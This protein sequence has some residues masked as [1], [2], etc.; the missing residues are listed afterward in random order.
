MSGRLKTETAPALLW[1]WLVLDF[2]VLVPKKRGLGF[3]KSPLGH[4]HVPGLS[5]IEQIA[6][7]DIFGLDGALLFQLNGN[8]CH[9]T[10]T[11]KKSFVDLVMPELEKYYGLCSRE[12]SVSDYF[13]LNPRFAGK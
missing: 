11:E 1:C 2:A 7:C 8:I 5:D 3:L 6:G 13:K 4:H 9:G 12:I 10:A